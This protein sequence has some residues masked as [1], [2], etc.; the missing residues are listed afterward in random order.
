[1]ITKALSGAIESLKTLI[2][3]KDNAPEKRKY[4]PSAQ[5]FP[6][7]VMPQLCLFFDRSLTGL[8]RRFRILCTSAPFII[9]L[10]INYYINCGAHSGAHGVQCGAHGVQLC[11]VVQCNAP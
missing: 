3:I 10:Y 7:R 9:Y 8:L 1:M 11:P 6:V 4:T 2:T 5:I